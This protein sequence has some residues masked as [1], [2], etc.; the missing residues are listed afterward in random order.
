[1]AGGFTDENA[2]LR[3]PWWIQTALPHP[4]LAAAE[5]HQYRY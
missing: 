5:T 1:M 4:E 3:E 2:G